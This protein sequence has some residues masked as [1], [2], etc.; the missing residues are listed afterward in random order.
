[1]LNSL[2][3]AAPLYDTREAKKCDTWSMQTIHRNV[4]SNYSFACY[5]LA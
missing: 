5:L 3:Y 2:L 4:T 1:M